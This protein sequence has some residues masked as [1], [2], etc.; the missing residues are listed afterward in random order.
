VH[1]HT[2]N[3]SSEETTCQSQIGS[4]EQLE[5]INDISTLFPRPYDLVDCTWK[6]FQID[7]LISH[8][9][10]IQGLRVWAAK[11]PKKLSNGSG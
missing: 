8:K 2:I 4:L 11:L 5:H 1:T 7:E 3:E 6:D 10:Y 9:A